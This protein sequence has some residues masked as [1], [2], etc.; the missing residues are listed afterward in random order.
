MSFV[1][2]STAIVQ[3]F[4]GALYGRQIG[5]VTMAAVNRDIDNVGL[6]STL[7]SY[8]AF[9][10][11]NETATQVATRVV[12]N[13]GITEGSANA[14]AYIVGVLGSKSA[15][16]WGQT[17]SEILAAFSSMT[18]DATY[19]AAATAWNTKVEAAAAYTGTTDVAIGTVVST[20]TL[21]ASK[22]KKQ[23]FTNRFLFNFGNTSACIRLSVFH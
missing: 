14:I 22:H 6:N 16:V 2:T 18:A 21:T 9:S 10:F 17:V 15:S 1:P 5:T 4:A 20:F 3:S 19:G 11:G 8:F 7:N 12:T 13:L 23:R